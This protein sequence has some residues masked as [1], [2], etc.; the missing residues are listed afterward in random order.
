MRYLKKLVNLM[1]IV[2][3]LVMFGAVGHADYQSEIGAYCSFNKLFTTM[4][5]GIALMIPSITMLIC[6]D[7]N[8]K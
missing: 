5:I 2:G 4:F 3:F 1:G 6:G 7:K 8:G